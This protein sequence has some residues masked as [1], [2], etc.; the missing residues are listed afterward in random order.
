[1]RLMVPALAA[2][3]QAEKRAID[4]GSSSNNW[5]GGGGIG[6]RKSGTHKGQTGHPS[7]VEV[8]EDKCTTPK[9]APASD[10][11]SH[12]AF[13]LHVGRF[14]HQQMLPCSLQLFYNLALHNYSRDKAQPCHFLDLL[15]CPIS[16]LAQSP[17][18]AIVI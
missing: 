2:W 3:I 5:G 17:R 13:P 14:S 10:R 11:F 6:K 4:R 9:P 16:Y 7:K 8:G 15:S 18:E 12:G 1:M